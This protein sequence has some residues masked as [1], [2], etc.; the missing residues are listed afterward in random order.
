V[1]STPHNVQKETPQNAS[2]NAC[3]GNAAI[4]L[5][6]DKVRPEEVEANQEVI[7]DQVPTVVEEPV[8]P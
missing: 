4:F 3:H 8:V 5:T 7:V 1:Y 6:A 2:C